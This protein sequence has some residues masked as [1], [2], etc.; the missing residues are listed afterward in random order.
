LEKQINQ[1]VN[2]KGEYYCNAREEFVKNQIKMKKLKRMI[3]S[4]KI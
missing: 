4:Q 3:I 1:I 2:N